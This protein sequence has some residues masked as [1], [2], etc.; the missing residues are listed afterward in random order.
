MEEARV[1]VTQVPSLRVP[2]GWKPKFD[3]SPAERYGRL[4]T[5]MPEGNAEPDTAQSAAEELCAALADFGPR[6]YLLPLGDPV[7]IAAAAA[8]AAKAS[9]GLIR[10]LRWDAKRRAYVLLNMRI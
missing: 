3:L 2:G 6:D 9:G 7:L 10:I 5:L 1:F 8:A 4:I